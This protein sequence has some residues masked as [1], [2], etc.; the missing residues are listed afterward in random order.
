MKS[1]VVY[2]S[3]FGNTEQVARSVAGS[4]CATTPVHIARVD[5]VSLA[6]LDGVNLLVI[7]CPT[8]SR[9]MTVA[10]E[11]FLELLP[12]GILKEMEVAVFDTRLEGWRWLTG[13][14]SYD[15]A[16]KLDHEGVRLILSPESFI[17]SGFE[18]PLARGE[19]KRAANWARAIQE[20][21]RLLPI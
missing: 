13:S 14:A 3:R 4:L 15:L 18:G 8:Q 21:L 1:L 20:Q 17:V 2:D 9:N 5:Q 12:R 19:L 16:K 6:D 10:T 11:S 7:G